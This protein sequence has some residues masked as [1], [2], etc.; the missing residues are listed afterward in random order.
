MNTLGRLFRLSLFG[1]S[2][3]PAIGA[4]IDGCPSGV[5][6]STGDFVADLTRRSR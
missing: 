1:E 5:P 3:G 6:L 4:L 2:H